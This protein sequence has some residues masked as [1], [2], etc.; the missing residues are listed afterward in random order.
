MEKK[1]FRSFIFNAYNQIL[2]ELIALRFATNQFELVFLGNEYS[3][4]WFPKNML[5]KKGTIF[6]V[7]LGHDSSFEFELENMGY[8]F[9]G[10]E[11]DIL[12]YNKSIK[13]FNKSDSRIFNYGIGTK[14][15]EVRSRGDNISIS[16]IYNH[17]PIN[18]QILQIRSLWEVSQYLKLSRCSQP[19]ILKMNIEGAEKEILNK[20]IR[21]PLAFEV[22]IFQA[23]FLFHLRFFKFYKRFQA[24]INLWKILSAF[25]K[26][27]WEVI[28]VHK[29][30]ITIL[31]VGYS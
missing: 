7:G 26:L 17:M 22:I 21:D 10:F 1:R 3:G 8:K 30:Q 12:S 31:Q 2:R 6:G 4:Y 18:S 23:E 13:Q 11:P 14:N 5:G 19:R 24:F 16:D 28:D 25:E 15:A 27:G 29:N 20:L 9:F